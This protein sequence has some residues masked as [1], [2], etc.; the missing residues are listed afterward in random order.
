MP[1]RCAGSS[2]RSRSL[3]GLTVPGLRP[4]RAAA[5]L[6]HTGQTFLFWNLFLAWLPYAAARAMRALDRRGPAARGPAPGRRV[7]ARV[8]AERA[9]PGDRPGAPGD[10]LPETA[11]AGLRRRAVR[12]RRGARPAARASPRWRPCTSSWSAASA[13]CRVDVRHDVSL[14]TAFGVYLGRVARWNSWAVATDP[15]PLLQDIDYRLNGH[16]PRMTAAV[17]LFAVCSWRPTRCAGQ[18]GAPRRPA[19]QD[20]PGRRPRRSPRVRAASTSDGRRWPG[21]SARS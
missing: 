11:P 5:A 1:S 9:V 21:A 7:L 4:A 8:P 2:C 13:R 18:G 15:R 3:A 17:L 20:P 12:R 16:G 6:G 19:P 14:A 10:R